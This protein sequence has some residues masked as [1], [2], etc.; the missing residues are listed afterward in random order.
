MTNT[1][2]TLPSV[3]VVVDVPAPTTVVTVD[4]GQRGP[5]GVPGNNG[6]ELYHFDGPVSSVTITHFM[7]RLP[8]VTLYIDGVNYLIGVTATTTQVSISFPGPTSNI[9]IILS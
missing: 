6:T 7:G 4:I 2:I 9:D 5:Q 1:T 8:A 3:A